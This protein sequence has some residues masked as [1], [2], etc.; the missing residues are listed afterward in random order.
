MTDSGS[1]LPK[2]FNPAQ[3]ARV[4][5]VP[6]FNSQDLKPG[7]NL[8]YSDAETGVFA[9]AEEEAGEVRC[10]QCFG[11]PDGTVDCYQIPC[12]DTPKTPPTNVQAWDRE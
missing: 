12:P 6:S 1:G 8:L 7:I 9:V 10:W 3:H 11:H 2:N 5:A 4:H